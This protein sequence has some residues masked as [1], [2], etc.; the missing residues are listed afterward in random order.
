M[1]S[2]CFR[3][4]CLS[5]KVALV[6]GG[7]S[8]IGKGIT[9]G[10][11]E[12]GCNVAIMSRNMQKL[13]EAAEELTSRIHGS[14]CFP[15]CADVRE[16]AS[17]GAAVD[18]TLTHFGQI[19]ILINAAAG[20]FLAPLTSLSY[21]GFKTV[22]EIDAH[23]TFITSK[24]VFHK[25]FHHHGGGVIINIS[26]TLHYC[27]AL[28]Q[29]HAGAAKAAVD[30]M[31]KH[32]AVEW[33]PYNVR[34]NGVAPGPVAGTEG[35]SR[36]APKQEEGTSGHGLEAFV[37][38]KR[39]GDVRDVSN[40]VA[41]LCTSEASYI[42]GTTIVVDGGQWLTSCNFTALHPVTNQTWGKL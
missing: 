3:P 17:V 5:G 20:N 6:T 29:T 18:L 40:M 34:V 25:C 28:L 9:Q 42:T 15:V 24:Q 1:S 4:N 14:R 32:M 2:S 19:D 38:L 31:T 37:P 27:G 23:G 36:L 41:F 22:M 16:E 26:M 10:L 13:K 7:G 30:A 21:K 8:G 12:L 35:L 11:L 33:G 39:L